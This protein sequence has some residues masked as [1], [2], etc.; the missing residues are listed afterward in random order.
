MPVTTSKAHAEHFGDADHWTHVMESLFVPAVEAAGF[1]PWRPVAR[2]SHL[3]HAEIVRQLERADMVLC[4]ISLNNPNVFFEQGVR[5]SVN[6]PVA[7]VR[8]D[9]DSPI[10]FDV[11]GMNA[12]TYNP[13]LKVWRN[14]AEIK[15]LTAHLRDAE[16]SCNGENPMWR[17]FGLELKAQEPNVP[18]TRED[19]VL[20]LISTQLADL[21]GRV[22]DLSRERVGETYI[23]NFRTISGGFVRQ[24]DPSPSGGTFYSHEEIRLLVDEVAAE[25]GINAQVEIDHGGVGVRISKGATKQ[26][27]ERFRAR[28]RE[29][30]A[31]MSIPVRFTH[32]VQRTTTA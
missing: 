32:S 25:N 10:P 9:A 3:I 14:D 15:A 24:Q 20:S 27:S 11:S 16:T 1:T 12:H 17:Q 19:A 22:E 21:S 4:D 7:L 29:E 26:Q 8:C 31:E 23:Q 13:S 5:T 28:V 30:L 2:G 18:E 6:R